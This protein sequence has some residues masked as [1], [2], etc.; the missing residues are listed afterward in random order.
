MDFT[1]SGVNSINNHLI[2]F[3]YE[4]FSYYASYGTEP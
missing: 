2:Q 3:H 1:N 4:K